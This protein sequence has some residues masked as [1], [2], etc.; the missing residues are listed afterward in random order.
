[1]AVGGNPGKST[2]AIQALRPRR[3]GAVVSANAETKSCDGGPR[4]KRAAATPF[5]VVGRGGD[6]LANR[7]VTGAR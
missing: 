7:P 6:T 5:G 4:E 3:G 1:M 2:N